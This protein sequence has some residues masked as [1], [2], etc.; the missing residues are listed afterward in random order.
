MAGSTYG[1]VWTGDESPLQI[2]AQRC[3]LA[4]E[5]RGG[6]PECLTKPGALTIR[7]RFLVIVLGVHAG[8]AMITSEQQEW[9]NAHA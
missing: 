7:C 8:C 3:A 4:A 1:V 6:A 9:I 5:L 2:I